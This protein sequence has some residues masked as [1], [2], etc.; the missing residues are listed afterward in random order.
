MCALFE[1]EI[2]GKFVRFKEKAKTKSSIIN[3][4]EEYV[5]TKIASVLECGSRV[6]S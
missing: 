4:L 1:Q 2:I 3:T 5:I 6:I